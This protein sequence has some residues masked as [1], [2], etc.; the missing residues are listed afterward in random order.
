MTL[1]H[2]NSSGRENEAPP[3]RIVEAHPLYINTIRGD[4]NV[5]T[6]NVVVKLVVELH[7]LLVRE[8][9]VHEHIRYEQLH[10]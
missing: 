4:E 3:T 9:T 8:L 10:L 7:S 5:Q 1:F 2:G 6:V